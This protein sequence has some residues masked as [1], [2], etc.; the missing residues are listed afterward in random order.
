VNSTY[1]I[2]WSEQNRADVRRLAR[3]TAMRIFES[4]LHY[5]RTRTGDIEPLHAELAGS[6]RLRVGDYRIVFRE[7]NDFMPDRRTC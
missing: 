4:V 7:V 5:D 3:A 6:F 2:E 1:R